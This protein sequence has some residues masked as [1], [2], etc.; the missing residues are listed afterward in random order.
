MEEVEHLPAQA[1]TPSSADA[2]PA[3]GGSGGPADVFAE[4]APSERSRSISDTIRAA[5]SGVPRP[6]PALKPEA[7][8]PDGGSA[9]QGDV[10]PSAGEQQQQGASPDAPRARDE[11]GRFLQRA[12]AG[13]S[14]QPPS[15]PA[16]QA[17]EA[18]QQ[19]YG[20]RGAA[21]RI[22]ELERQLAERDPEKI[23]Q[24]VLAELSQQQAQEA[25]EQKAVKDAER[26]Q[27]LLSTPDHLLSAED[28]Q[29]REEQKELIEKFPDV[30]DFVYAQADQQIKAATVDLD[31]KQQAFW[32]DLKG[33]MGRLASL[34]GVDAQAY[35]RLGRFD[36]MGR[37][38]YDAGARSRDDEV[39][40]LQRQLRE[41]DAELE[42][43]APLNGARGF[44]SGRA[45]VA[46]G[47]SGSGLPSTD[48]NETFR[49][50]VM[51][52]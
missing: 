19:Q 29:W 27:K 42:R 32:S 13:E 14:H 10:K 24:Q 47:R 8:A 34:K 40:D 26:F 45:P 3:A 49:R 41:K 38:L 2:Q 16:A 44:G 4:P 17:D 39:A 46:A 28:Y 12:A 7:T 52:R 33:Q 48:M 30:R 22:T 51:G 43:H 15:A 31:Q 35:A 11:R 25:V 36:Q 5:A 23:R 50:A 21:E 18:Q 9:P 20:R 6:A 1:D 37:H